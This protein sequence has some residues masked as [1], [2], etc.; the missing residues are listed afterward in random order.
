MVSPETSRKKDRSKYYYT[1]Y[2]EKT[3][4]VVAFGTARQCAE[5]MGITYEH[6]QS[7]VSK[8]R[9]G[10]RMKHTFIIEELPEHEE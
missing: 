9:H 2:L 8:W 7:L 10:K 6:F 1:V 4:K 3:D 5:M